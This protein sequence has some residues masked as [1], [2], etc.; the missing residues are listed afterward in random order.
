LPVL[1]GLDPD[2]SQYLCLCTKLPVSHQYP[3]TGF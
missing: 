2:F 1:G 3:N